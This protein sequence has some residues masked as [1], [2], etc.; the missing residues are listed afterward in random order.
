MEFLSYPLVGLPIGLLL[1]LALIGKIYLARHPDYWER[2]RKDI[3]AEQ[4]IHAKLPYRA[5]H[6][7]LTPAE[8]NFYEAMRP[9]V[10]EHWRLFSKV[11]M[12]DILEVKPGLERKEA[13]GYRSRIKSRHIDFVL[14]DQ[15]S[16]QVLLCIEL[17]DSSHQRR[18]Q[19]EIDDCKDQAMRDAGPTLTRVPVQFSYSEDYLR[20]LLFEESS[21]PA[22]EAA[23]G[24]I[25]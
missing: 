8:K 23:N 3:K 19:K 15:E 2:I 7:L 18:K 20:E 22:G 9:L 1:L 11:R 10:S 13:Y 17:D 21:M 6:S 5:R 14:C 25:S 12:E 4:A 24:V 16:L